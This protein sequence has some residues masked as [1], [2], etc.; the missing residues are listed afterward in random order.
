MSD[1]GGEVD[2]EGPGEGWAD[3]GTRDG[4]DRAGGSPPSSSTSR[5]RGQSI[6]IGGVRQRPCLAGRTPTRQQEAGGPGSPPHPSLSTATDPPE[7]SCRRIGALLVRARPTAAGVG[8]RESRPAGDGPSPRACPCG[9]HECRRRDDGEGIPGEQRGHNFGVVE[10]RAGCVSLWR[11][12]RWLVWLWGEVR[13]L[14]NGERCLC[15]CGLGEGQCGPQWRP[16]R[17]AEAAD[18]TG[19]FGGACHRVG[20]K[21]GEGSRRQLDAHM[22]N[23]GRGKFLAMNE[24]VKNDHSWFPRPS[25]APSLSARTLVCPGLVRVC[26]SAA[27]AGRD[28][29]GAPGQGRGSETSVGRSCSALRV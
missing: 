14:S 25:P 6:A 10:K 4:K 26:V 7:A 12:S 15:V 17:A 23:E 28:A 29:P 5:P 16:T 13:L 22:P 19:L 20:G 21:V 27:A 11:G 3:G 9:C 1:D 8:D 18:R 24:F 2:D